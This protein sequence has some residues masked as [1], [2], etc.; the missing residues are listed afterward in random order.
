MIRNLLNTVK[1]YWFNVK[2]DR[3]YWQLTLCCLAFLATQVKS[4]CPVVNAG[5]NVSIYNTQSTQLN[6]T[7]PGGIGTYTYSWSPSTGLSNPNIANPV[8][9]PLATT[10]Y[11]V[12]ATTNVASGGQVVYSEN[13]V[14]NA[15]PSLQ[16]ATTWCT[17]RS[18]L[19]QTNFTTLTLKGTF[20]PVGI[21]CTDPTTVQ[22]IANALRTGNSGT[23]S[24][25]GRTWHVGPGCVAG[26]PVACSTAVELSADGTFCA[27]GG[28]SYIIRPDVNNPFWGGVNTITCGGPSQNMQVIFTY[29]C[30]QVSTSSVAVSMV[31]PER[32]LKFNGIN[33]YVSVPNGMQALTD[34][35]AEGWLNLSNGAVNDFKTILDFDTWQA[36]A[37]HLQVA[38]DNRLELSVNGVG[39]FFSTSTFPDN[40]WKHFAAV[41]ST[42][43]NVIKIYMNGNLEFNVP[44]TG[45][46]TISGNQAFR[47]GSWTNQRFFGGSMDELRIWNTERT[48]SQIQ[49]NMFCDVPQQSGL[50]QYYRFNQG[51]AGGT[52]TGILSASDFSGNS[53]CTSL[54]GFTLTGTSSN[55]ISGIVPS[56]TAATVAL[57]E[58]N[59][60]GNNIS[61]TDGDNTSSVTDNTDM[62]TTTAGATVSKSFVIENTGNAPLNISGVTIN[63]ANASSFSITTNAPAVIAAGTAATFVVSF[64]A[65]NIGT[66]TATISIANNDCDEASYDF[67]IQAKA[68]SGPAAVNN[69]VLLWLDA[70]D[71]DADGNSSNDP[72]TNTA[73]SS[74]KDR[75]GFSHDATIFPGQNGVSFITNQVNGKPVV[76]F[77]RVNDNLGSVLETSGVD[78]RA[79]ANPD[80]TIFTVYKPGTH[81]AGGQGQSLWGNDNGA[82]DRFYYSSWN[83]TD[84]GIA[85]LGPLA[86]NFTGVTGAGTP[87]SLRLMTAVFDGTLSGGTN[88]GPV[89]G[90]AIY[91]NGAVVTTFT[92]QTDPVAAQPNLGIGWDGDNGTYNGDIAEMIVYNRKL[93]DCEILQ[94]N[95]YLGQKYGVVFTSATIT[96]AGATSICAGGTVTLN[97]SA[98]SGYVW[99][100]DGNVIPGA[101]SS[102]YSA[103]QAGSYTVTISNGSCAATSLATVVSVNPLP[104]APVAVNAAR[105]SSGT[106]TISA[107]PAAGETIDWYNNI[108][109]VTPVATGNN[110]TTP[111]IAATTTY[112]AQ[113][114]NISTGCVSAART[115]VT[116]T[117]NPLPSFTTTKTNVNCAG[118]SDG[119]ITVT[120]TGSGTPFQYSINGGT[121]YQAGNTFTGLTAATYNVVVKNSFTC[122]STAQAVIIGTVPDVTPPVPAVA[123]LPTITG[124]CSASATAP[125][126]NDVCNGV[127]T[128]TTTDPLTYNS[129]GTFTIHWTYKDA[130]GNTSTQNQTVIVKDITFPVFSA[131]GVAVPANILTNVP[132]ANQYNLVYQ[133]NIPNISNYN[134]PSDVA[135]AIN[136]AAALAGVPFSRIAYYMELDNKWVWVSM[137]KFTSSLSQIGIPTGALG[138]QQKVNN[139]NVVASSNAAV[140]TGNTI[141]TGNIEFWSNCY[142]T[143]N[144]LGLPN[145]NGGTYD[146]DD[147]RSTVNCYGSFQVHNY[148]L[149]QTLFAYNRWSDDGN[150]ISDLGI[151]NQ[152]GGSGHPDWTF[153]SNANTY[154]SKK[155]YIFISG[156]INDINA[157]T[158]INACS[159]TVNI[160]VPSATDNCGAPSVTG[161]RSDNLALNALYPKGVTT[162][163][164]SAKDVAGNTTTATQ[165]VTV[166]DNEKPVLQGVPSNATVQCTAVAAPANVTA[167]DN[168][169]GLSVVSFNETRTDG[170]CAGNYTLT[171]TWSVTDASNNTTTATQVITVQDTQAPVITTAAGSLNRTIECSDGTG[172]TAALAL[173]PAATDNCSGAS[174]RLLTDNTTASC[175]ST[176]TRVRTWNFVD[177]C[178]NT[179]T[180]F[181]QTITV[182]DRTAPTFTRPANVTIYT[183]A[184]CSYN[185]S[186]TNTGD[187]TNEADNCSTGLQAT[188]TDVITNGACEG[189]HIITRT[190]HLVDNCGNAATDQVQTIT[191]EDKT[192]PVLTLP[193]DIVVNNDEG[194]C[195]ASVSFLAT[196]SDNC[197]T[198]VIT[199]SI[200]PGSFFNEGTTTVTV[201]ALDACGNLVTGAFTVTVTDNE[202]PTITA[203]A[204]INV[205]NTAGKCEATVDLGTPVTADNCGVA[206][207]TNDHASNI[208]PVGTTTVTWTVTDIHGHSSIAAQTVVVTDNENPTITA[209]ANISVNNTVGKCEATV[210][211]GRPVTADNCG[212][213]SVTNDHASN[214]YPVGT[215]TVTWTV[216]DIHGHSSTAAQTVVVTDNEN[217]IANCKPVTVTLVNG[218][219]NITVADIN[220]NSTDNCGI[221]SKTISKYSFNCLNLGPNTVTLTVTDIHGNVSTCS[222]IVTVT[223]EVPNCS[224]ASLPTDNTY[225]GGINTNLYLGYGAQSTILK[226]TGYGGAPYTYSWSGAALNMLN[227]NTSVAPVFTPAA[228]GVYSFTV[229]TTNK[230]GC[231]ST[232][233]ITICVKDIRVPGLD[234]KKVYVCH[235]PLGNSNNPNTLSISTNAVSSHIGQHAGDKLGACD[236]ACGT[237]AIA[238]VTD[239]PESI[240]SI[241]KTQEKSIVTK[242][243][244]EPSM[245]ISPVPNR[246]LFNLQLINYPA[247][248]AEIRITDMNGKI[249]LL[250]KVETG[251]KTNQF[252]FDLTGKAQGTYNITVIGSEKILTGKVIIQR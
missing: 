95:Q 180:A 143:G 232:C 42:T 59:V 235:V 74:W 148:G 140:T 149:K 38:P 217:P 191:I 41:F 46:Q 103:T 36:G 17:F 224:I 177:A 216:T 12:T 182:T 118:G 183:N 88:N 51:I 229:V 50:I 226:V 113:A 240:I 134:N 239:N 142:I 100:R 219:A 195:G 153:Q 233:S 230:Y 155:L 129:Q 40:V 70:S 178:G 205:N 84:D 185:A 115:A 228:A 80:I 62:G 133:L 201:K 92:D 101:T 52:N 78:I 57:T 54:N 81:S 215:T 69:G 91:F 49:N 132:E 126:A 1:N 112:Y 199:Y 223:G 194:R 190:W 77:T 89:N 18:Q 28:S 85:S 151:G 196:A 198:P 83:N 6:A 158:D 146:F 163:T 48:Q 37:L 16:A 55:F 147:T 43:N 181:T 214:I 174:I 24:S 39:D 23:F 171:R 15:S 152:V 96:P 141:A 160:S 82:W 34:V 231:T 4:Q 122:A 200:E 166:I 107:T 60:K 53:T 66:N 169:P 29:G 87:G 207:V 247:G 162:I 221:A 243:A 93:S 111:V 246:G 19:I 242:A 79:G 73:L 94:I 97:A 22:A 197:S 67:T 164:W 238:R 175:G 58:I 234:G 145:A 176:Y 11:T 7:V 99:L 179:S 119:S 105:C 241:D 123:T 68:V 154:T 116:A 161:V 138:F 63:G 173:V 109:D 47:L 135:Y 193:A 44:Y 117:V 184:D 31:P 125:V 86:P 245:K 144:A 244:I 130:S 136:N 90:S 156:G 25:G 157:N 218:T 106:V 159:A 3:K 121:T 165:K 167:S 9:S 227:S 206:S 33:N 131:A 110:F 212:V 5:S 32:A 186:V 203:P 124:E 202:N 222:S 75:S 21:T 210:D 127:I 120:A 35:T 27:C 30:S 14:N 64:N 220:N 204:N 189:S 188:F 104:A 236:Q 61:I 213:A 108:S 20:D 251:F 98:G 249:L 211:L 248:K 137:D 72:A 209:P 252:N 65:T 250:R 150:N 168:C 102:S 170:N 8:A 71:V 76:H 172:I 26:S 192:A 56:C 237:S 208:Y 13:F 10:T 139:M 128:A 45:S 2:R 187:V 225:T 114:R